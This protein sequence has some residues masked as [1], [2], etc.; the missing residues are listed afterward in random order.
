M[1]TNLNLSLLNDKGGVSIPRATKN[2]TLHALPDIIIN[3]T[4]YVITIPE[5]SEAYQNLR[6]IDVHCTSS[7]EHDNIEEHH[8]FDHWPVP[9][10]I[11]VIRIPP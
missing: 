10:M 4:R 1:S 8:F 11:L 2:K 3:S 6:G 5:I 9:L 7:L